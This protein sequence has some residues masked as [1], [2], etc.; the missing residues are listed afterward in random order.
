MVTGDYAEMS[1]D[2]QQSVACQLQVWLPAVAYWRCAISRNL[3]LSAQRY[4]PGGR[5]SM[6]RDR[7][8]ADEAPD[9]DK[10]LGRD[11]RV[12]AW[13]ASFE[14]VVRAVYR[15][16]RGKQE[17]KADPDPEPTDGSGK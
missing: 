13:P 7:K 16:P 12:S 8:P 11:D 4:E 2:R 6:D 5:L 15:S 14:D 10:P 17:P 3:A 9:D 1:P